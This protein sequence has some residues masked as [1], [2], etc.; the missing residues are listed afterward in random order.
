MKTA[1]ALLRFSSKANGEG[2]RGR[3]WERCPAGVDALTAALTSGRRWLSGVMLLVFAVTFTFAQTPSE[4]SKGKTFKAGADRTDITPELG[5][6]IVGSFA[7]QPATH[8]HDP[9]YVR[10]LVLDD[11]ITRIALVVCD[12]LGL[13]QVVCDEAKRLI[14]E[15][16]GIPASHVV[17]ASTHSHSA[18]STRETVQPSS[19]LWDGFTGK[20]A[21]LTGYQQFVA[22]RVADSVQVAINRLEPARIGWGA[23]SEPRH[24]FNRRWFVKD[25][26]LR[27][28][29]FGGV[30]K[31]RMNPPVASP[32]LV[33]PAGPTDPDVLFLSVQT[34]AGKPL[35]VFANYTLHYVGG[36]PAGAISA[37]YFGAFAA[38]L[39]AWLGGDRGPSD[40]PFIAILSNGASGDI[41]NIDFRNRRKASEP[42][43][44]MHRVA[45]SIAAEVFRVY[46]AIEY[47]DWVKLDAKLSLLTLQPRRPTRE[48]IAAAEAIQA[49]PE[50]TK[51]QWHP[52]EALYAQRILV[53][54][55]APAELS[56]PVQA[57][58]IGDF[59][60]AALPVEALVEVGL[61]LKAKSG[62]SKTMVMGISNGYFGYMPTETQH[63]L[64]G[65]ESWL[66]SNRLETKAAPK[67]VSSLLE[68]LAEL[69]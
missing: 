19:G 51:P 6:L 5:V 34:A 8:I 37:D 3:R 43:E 11:G 4:S 13:P 31:V 61:E 44:H 47:K 56:V 16:T 48:M 62:Y 39:E 24:V 46:Q 63:A 42:Y 1:I 25:E 18:G 2:R 57:M 58:R 50:G 23:G 67:M 28:N 22:H 12:N 55:K 14:T 29:P 68:M 69:R 32:E 30:D 26:A 60:L 27:R 20:P 10:T 45:N 17:I 65:Y 59:G 49:R 64:G 54:A 15:R 66:G 21:E 35:A 41:N 33:E 52:V 9:L 40:S 38:K 53:A 7:P 36:I